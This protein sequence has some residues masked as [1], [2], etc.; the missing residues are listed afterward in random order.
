[1]QNGKF[2]K[3]ARF[4]FMG[5]ILTTVFSFSVIPDHYS[6]VD[7]AEECCPVDGMIVAQVAVVSDVDVSCTDFLQG[8]ELQRGDALLFEDEQ[9]EATKEGRENGV[10][11]TLHHGNASKE[12]E[13]CHILSPNC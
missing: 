9:G 4:M 3:F 7:G 13:G 12:K 2:A 10:V 5:D 1:M 6:L 11:S 8:L